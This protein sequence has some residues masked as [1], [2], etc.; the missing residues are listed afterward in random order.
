M[1]NNMRLQPR[2]RDRRIVRSLWELE[3]R[4]KR[5]RIVDAPPQNDGDSE[6]FH[7][8]QLFFMH[9]SRGG[10]CGLCQHCLDN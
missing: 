3:R 7:C 6:C 10:S 9:Q 4:L 1:A 5:P 8:G 2:V